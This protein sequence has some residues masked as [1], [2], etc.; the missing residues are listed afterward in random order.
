MVH[1]LLDMV[2]CGGTDSCAREDEEELEELLKVLGYHGWRKKS[3]GAGETDDGADVVHV[4][5]RAAS[6][7]EASSVEEEDPKAAIVEACRQSSTG[8]FHC[9]LCG[10]FSTDIGFRLL[11]HVA[12]HYRE[13]IEERCREE[14]RGRFPKSCRRCGL[15]CRRRSELAVHLFDHHGEMAGQALEDIVGKDEVERE[16]EEEEPVFVEVLK[17]EEDNES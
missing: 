11:R 10:A 7:L 16:D 15:S 12:T 3:K 4:G 13:R 5:K 17:D 8:H 6:R 2:S 1:L 14:L 9:Q